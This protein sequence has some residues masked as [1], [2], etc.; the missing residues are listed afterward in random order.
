MVKRTLVDEDIK[1]GNK[2]IE[3]LDSAEFAVDAA[4]WYYFDESEL[5]RLVIATP[6]KN[7]K[8]PKAAY[9]EIQRIL[10]ESGLSSQISLIDITLF[11]PN[12]EIIR[13]IRSAV[14]IRSAEGVRFSRSVLGRS[15]IDDAL[16]YVSGSTLTHSSSST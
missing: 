15:Y 14:N 12:D 7:E 9:R 10:D 1:A 8:G 3:A 11:S 2:L 16:I 5:W 13:D 6:L 4:M